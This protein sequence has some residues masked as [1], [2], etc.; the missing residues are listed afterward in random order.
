VRWRAVVDGFSIAVNISP[1]SLLDPGFVDEV[2]RALA[3]VEVPSSALVLEITETSLMA[4]PE[5]AITAL[6]RLRD[7]GIRLS[8]D[9]LGTG[10]SSLA[11]LQRLPV[12]EVK[13]DRSFLAELE[14]AEAQAVVGAIV[15][16]GHR[17]GKQVVAEGV[18]REES[19]GV[20][21]AMGC[22]SAQGFWIARPMAAVQLT[23]FLEGGPP[24]AAGSLRLVQ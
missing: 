19:L 21:R 18:E 7:L 16:L 22:D 15:E 20:L 3:R 10:Y 8:V 2:A 14:T 5:R 13:I 9:D 24:R 23:K 1:R 11:Y 6:H 17:L 12:D 4:D